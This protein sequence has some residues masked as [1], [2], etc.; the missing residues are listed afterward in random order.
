MIIHSKDDEI[1]PFAHGKKLF[2]E[3]Q[4]HQRSGNWGAYG[5]SVKRLGKVLQ[6]LSALAK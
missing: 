1:V 5:E 4:G 2:E 6:N 3:S